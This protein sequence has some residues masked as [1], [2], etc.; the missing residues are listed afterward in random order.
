[1]LRGTLGTDALAVFDHQPNRRL[2]VVQPPNAEESVI[3]LDA[4]RGPRG[5]SPD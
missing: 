5:I 4:K 1:M 3:P 2:H